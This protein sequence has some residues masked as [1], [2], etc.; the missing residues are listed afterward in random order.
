M[1]AERGVLGSIII[2]PDMPAQLGFLKPEHFYRDAHRTI[3]EVIQSL[4]AEHGP[5]DLITIS[6][7]LRSLGKLDEVG[8]SGYITSL[9]NEVPTSIN[10]IHYGRIVERLGMCRMAIEGIQDLAVQAYGG[11]LEDLQ[12][13]LTAMTYQ[14]RVQNQASDLAP[15]RTM[16]AE[17]MDNL[18]ALQQHTQSVAGVPTGLNDLDRLLGGMGRSDLL[19]L[20]ARPAIGKSSLSLSIAYNV[21]VRAKKGVAVFSLEMGKQQLLQRLIAMD[22]G[23]DQQRLRTGW[24]EDDEWERIMAATDRLDAS[25]LYIDDTVGI[26]PVEILGKVRRVMAEG[27]DIQF[28]V[29]DYLQLMRSAAG[30]RYGSREQE[31]AEISRELKGIARELNVPVLALAQLSR[32]VEGRQNKV[33]QLSDLRESGAIENDADVVMFI[34]RD[35][36]YN[37]ET[38]RRNIADIIVAKHR[39]GPVGE[40]SLYFH[41][42][43]TYFCDL[44]TSSAAVAGEEEGE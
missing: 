18:D 22:A 30:K 7:R 40:V 12:E 11:N 3:Y 25:P 36:V 39:N 43:R 17:F 13:Q 6:D 28:V 37:P 14:L 1:E 41:K 42:N 2:D 4:A 20:A 9:I 21:A 15:V 5:G 29:V 24:I 19:I 44:E 10:A 31:I 27:V 23:I 8:G 38:E 32:A 34:Y 35:E 26:T 33:P 16:L